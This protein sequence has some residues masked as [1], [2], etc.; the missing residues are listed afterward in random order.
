VGVFTFDSI[1][2][3][4]MDLHF[5]HALKR[6]DASSTS[7]S[8][9]ASPVSITFVSSGNLMVLVRTFQWVVDTTWFNSVESAFNV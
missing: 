5:G 8:Y 1:Q 9:N 6:L 7:V 2:K 4:S 3:P